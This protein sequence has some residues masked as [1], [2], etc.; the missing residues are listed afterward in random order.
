LIISY[1]L[2][3]ATQNSWRIDSRYCGENAKGARAKTTLVGVAGCSVFRNFKLFF[4]K[5][6]GGEQT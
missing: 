1:K 6:L 5:W 3:S 4:L 2:N